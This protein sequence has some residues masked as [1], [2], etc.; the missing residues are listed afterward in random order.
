MYNLLT[1]VIS[2]IWE[3]NLVVVGIISQLFLRLFFNHS[4]LNQSISF[5]VC[6]VHP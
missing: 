4:L 2:L 1:L 6:Q 3:L 5:Q